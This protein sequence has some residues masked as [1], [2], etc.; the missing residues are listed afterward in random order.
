MHRIVA[1]TFAVDRI[2]GIRHRSADLIAGINILQVDM[3][4]A[5]G[6]VFNDIVAQ[7]CT[8]IRKPLVTGIILLVRRVK[9]ILTGALG[10]D[11]NRMVAFFQTF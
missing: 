1:Q 11:N 9:Q 3:R 6:K 8:D 4:I 7:E 2:V 5:A 10:N